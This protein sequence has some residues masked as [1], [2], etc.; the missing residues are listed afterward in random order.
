[1]ANSPCGLNESDYTISVTATDV[2]VTVTGIDVTTDT[3]VTITGV[4]V[5]TDADVTITGVDVTTD[6]DAT[7]TGVNETT[8]DVDVLDSGAGPREY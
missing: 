2:N 1:M 3:D 5:T 7:A 8:T 4:D 6:A